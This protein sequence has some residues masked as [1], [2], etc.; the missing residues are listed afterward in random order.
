MPRFPPLPRSWKCRASV[1]IHPLGTLLCNRPQV[2]F[3]EYTV[4]GGTEV[5]YEV[6][7]GL[8]TAGLAT[9]LCSWC[10]SPS[11][12]SSLSEV[13]KRIS[14][15]SLKRVSVLQQRPHPDTIAI[16]I[17][18]PLGGILAVTAYKLLQRNLLSA[19]LETAYDSYSIVIMFDDLNC[20]HDDWINR[21]TTP[22]GSV[23]RKFADCL[24]DCRRATVNQD[25]IHN[26]GT[27]IT[28]FGHECPP[29]YC[30]SGN[31]TFV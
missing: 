15:S 12:R 2:T 4:Y 18:R 30:L 22:N 21:L 5:W 13:L 23:C 26:K 8:D 31:S 3:P 9:G 14:H 17:R 29:E 19:D 7:Q 1:S 27:R 16:E 24:A 11:T 10:K 6:C 25:S 20:N 28:L